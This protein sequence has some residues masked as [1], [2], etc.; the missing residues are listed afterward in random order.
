[1]IL[2]IDSGTTGVTAIAVS[3]QGEIIA[4]GYQ[5]FPQ[6]FPQPGWVEHNLE[7]IWAAVLSSVQ[8]VIDKV[9]NE[10]KALGITNQR[11]T[12]GLWDRETLHS[13]RNAIVWQDRRT[14]E[15]L[16]DLENHPTFAKVQALTGLPLDPYFS[17]AKLRWIAKH[18]PEIWKDVT[19]G[20]TVVGTI[21]SYVIARATN[22]IHITDA[23]NA[24][25]TQLYD[26]HT[27][28]WSEELT[29]L[30]E[31]PTQ[32]LPTIVNSSGVVATTAPGS[33]FGLAIPISGIAGDQ[34][35]A[36]FG[37]TQFQ[38]G[39]AK[40][41]YG[42]GAFILQNIGNTPVVQTNGLITTVAW[43]LNGV[44]TYASEGSVFVAG[45]AVQWLRD[46]LQLFAHSDEVEALAASVPDSAGVV[47][48]PA[49]TGLGAPYWN[50]EAR[51]A[52]LGLTRGTSKAHI[53]RATLEALAFQVR[54]IFEAMAST[55]IK[56]SH[57]RVDG[58]A[59]QNDLMLQIQADQLD[60]RIER[61]VNIDSTALGAAYLAGL[62]VGI[63]KSLE[64]LK[65]LNPIEVS[66]TKQND[67]EAGYSAWKRAVHATI[68]FT[69]K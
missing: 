41:T 36:L 43:Q 60:V 37:Q 32:A 69:E 14:T 15:I 46:E 53:A 33:F 42:T 52:L 48:V 35:A 22:G 59:S 50:P 55:G 23:S 5:E 54:D 29:E 1:M 25:R 65:E 68:A 11:E 13:P 58:G 21:D 4:R 62:G 49:L 18:E 19:T 39:G 38:V 61:P 10:F 56:L 31:V 7:E 9:G 30:F 66:F 51:G 12:I 47:F 2:A 64:E 34:Q 44:R 6:H 17:A 57:L 3:D 26:I 28:S 8:Q 63:W 16:K 67:S 24:S 20:N 27:G 40:C 45:A